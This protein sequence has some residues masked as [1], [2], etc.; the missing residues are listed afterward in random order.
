MANS[1]QTQAGHAG[2]MLFQAAMDAAD[3]CH[4]DHRFTHHSFLTVS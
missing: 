2:L 3:L 4:F 1:S